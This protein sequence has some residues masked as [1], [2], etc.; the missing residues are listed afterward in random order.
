M[1]IKQDYKLI[2][3]AWKDALKSNNLKLASELSDQLKKYE[4]VV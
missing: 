2:F 3:E 1:T 4:K